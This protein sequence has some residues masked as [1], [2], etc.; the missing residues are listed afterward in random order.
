MRIRSPYAALR[1]PER[2]ALRFLASNR[3]SRFRGGAG[4]TP[5]IDDVGDPAGTRVV[6]LHGGGDSR[7][8]RHPDDTIARAL[9]VRLLAV[10]RCGPAQRHGSLRAWADATVDVLGAGSFGVVGWSAGGPHALALAAAAPARV[11]RVALVGSMP[12]PDLVEELPRDVRSAMRLARVA[13]RLAARGLERW[14]RLPVPPT[15]DTGTDDAYA[16]GRVESFRNGGLWLARE[17]A[18]LGRPWGFAL[19]DVRAPVT[20][21]WGERDT[22][23]PPS[24]GRAYA[25]R[26]P[27]AELRLV[28][29]THQLLFARWRDILADVSGQDE[30]GL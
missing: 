20:L 10:D 1:D 24:I 7:L 9:G 25:E 11:T 4:V 27:N 29:G 21:W 17:L 18:Y 3:E 12:P 23:C 6:Y 15:G 5:P 14:G 28:D 30:P 2:E 13:P 22:V 26:L 16:R 8:S 19:S